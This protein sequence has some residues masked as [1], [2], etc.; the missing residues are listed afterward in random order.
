[1][2]WAFYETV[3]HIE[4]YE[5]E[6]SL[7]FIDNGKRSLIKYEDIKVVYNPFFVEA[8]SEVEGKVKHDAK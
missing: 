1:M 8:T 5:I 4:G 2:Q 7:T 6:G 3:F